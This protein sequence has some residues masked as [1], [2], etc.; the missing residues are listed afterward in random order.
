[1]SRADATVVILRHGRNA[2]TVPGGRVARF[3]AEAGNGG[4][5]AA[6]ARPV[7]HRR[8]GERIVPVGH[9]CGGERIVGDHPRNRDR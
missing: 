2:T 3:P 5:V 9:R 4:P 6:M 1:M 7:G 8:G